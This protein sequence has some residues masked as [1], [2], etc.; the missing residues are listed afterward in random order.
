M[1]TGIETS[2]IDLANALGKVAGVE[3]NIVHAD[4]RRGELRHSCL[5]GSKLKKL[6]WKPATELSDGL[7]ATFDYIKTKD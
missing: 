2:V 4:E 3:S 7:R 6:G 5:D 1:G